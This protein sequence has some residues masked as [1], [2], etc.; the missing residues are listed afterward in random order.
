MAGGVG[1]SAG[2]KSGWGKSDRQHALDSYK[3]KAP[4]SNPDSAGD[5]S[6]V[7]PLLSSELNPEASGRYKTRE[8][9]L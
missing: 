4:I 5:G 8:R 2:S 1:S 6:P 9:G 3:D 7:S